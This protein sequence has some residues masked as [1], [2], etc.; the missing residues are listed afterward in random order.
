MRF[1]AMA[2]SCRKII[3][4]VCIA[5]LFHSQSYANEVII[6]N[7]QP[8][9]AEKMG[10]ILFPDQASDGEET[11]VP[12]GIKT[13]SISFGKKSYVPESSP[14]IASEAAI[15]SIGLPIQFS[16]NSSEILSKSVPFLDEV[17]K[18]MS[19]E[20]YQDKR[21]LIEGHTD[22]V[23]SGQYNK[24]LS[25]KRAQA[26]KNY[27]VDNHQ[28]SPEKLFIRGRGEGSPLPNTNPKAS[29]NRR[30]QFYNAE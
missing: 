18:M 3:K 30:V 27:L 13:R 7:D 16:S 19:L 25:E 28:I 14:V 23:G 2:L 29:A 6:F 21:L 8:P 1:N 11:N 20:T 26:V 12:T 15:S 17:G 22:A 9:S 4:I 5:F 24:I 10:S